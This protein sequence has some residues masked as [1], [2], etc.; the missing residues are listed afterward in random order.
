MILQGRYWAPDETPLDELEGMIG[1][2]YK[3]H[4]LSTGPFIYLNNEPM[5]G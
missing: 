2:Y 5:E 1:T 4:R 3:R